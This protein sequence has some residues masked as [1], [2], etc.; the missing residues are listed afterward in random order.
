[1]NWL[2]RTIGAVAPA[3]AL[4]RLRQRQALLHTAGEFRRIPAGGASQSDPLQHLAGRSPCCAAAGAEKTSPIPKPTPNA[5]SRAGIASK[6]SSDWT[7]KRSASKAYPWGF[8]PAREFP[9][10]LLM[11]AIFA[12]SRRM[13]SSEFPM[14][15]SHSR[16]K[17]DSWLTKSPP[18]SSSLDLN[19]A[20]ESV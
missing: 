15:E 4:R 16:A 18:N 17:A 12:L 11:R 9:R 19:Q 3:V 6:P 13:G 14:A 20:L 10:I 1:M 7:P 2:D 5:S 8:G